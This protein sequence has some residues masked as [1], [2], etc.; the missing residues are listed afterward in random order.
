VALQD[1]KG[2]LPALEWQTRD[3]L[4]E[5]AGRFRKATGLD[6]RVRSG[7]RTCAE[8]NGLYAQGRDGAGE[9]ITYA[10]GCT[11]WHVLGRAADLDPITP[12]GVGQAESAYRTAGAIWVSMGGVYGGNFS[13][14][15]DIGHFEWHPGLTIGQVCPSPTYC[16]AIEAAIQTSMP[17]VRY[18]ALGLLVGAGALGA[19]RWARSRKLLA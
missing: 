6:L 2:Y 10:S 4:V 7:R 1:P 9:I 12:A 14:F 5:L 15:P 17:A 18:L 11:S 19:L 13:G 16:S 3:K 8:Q